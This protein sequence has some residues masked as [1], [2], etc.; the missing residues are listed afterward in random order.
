MWISRVA[1]VTALAMLAGGCD[2]VVGLQEL[3][4]ATDA[5]TIDLG[6]ATR[7]ALL[8]ADFEAGTTFYADRVPRDIPVAVGNVTASVE[9]N[10]ASSGHALVVDTTGDTYRL[11][12]VST[13]AATRIT[14]TFDLELAHFDATAPATALVVLYFEQT[15]LDQCYVA[16]DY[17]PSP[18]RLALAENCTSQ[19]AA[20]LGVAIPSHTQ[21]V[22]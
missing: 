13:T 21:F 7:P 1:G 9:A 4:P 10:A 16:L 11:E 14:A 12:A 22:S 19:Q 2:Y 3:G 17:Q 6:C 18:P 5:S 20:N 15:S 8:C